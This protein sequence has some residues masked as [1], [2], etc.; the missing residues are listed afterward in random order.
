MDSGN[1]FFN[2]LAQACM[3]CI[4]GQAPFSDGFCPWFN[5]VGPCLTSNGCGGG[6]IDGR[7]DE[8]VD[9]FQNVAASGCAECDLEAAYLC[10]DT[11]LLVPVNIVN[12]NT[13]FTQAQQCFDSEGCSIATRD[14]AL[15]F[16]PEFN[17]CSG[18]NTGLDLLQCGLRSIKLPFTDPL[19]RPERL[20]DGFCDPEYNVPECEFDAGDCCLFPGG[21][22]IENGGNG[23]FAQASACMACLDQVPFDP[24]RPETICAFVG[25]SVNCILSNNCPPLHPLFGDL[26]NEVQIFGDLCSD[27]NCD[28]GQAVVCLDALKGNSTNGTSTSNTTSSGLD[29]SAISEVTE[30]LDAAGC[31]KDLVLDSIGVGNESKSIVEDCFGCVPSLGVEIEVIGERKCGIITIQAKL[32]ISDSCVSAINGIF[33]SPDFSQFF[34][35]SWNIDIV[36]IGRRLQGPGAPFIPFPF[37]SNQNRVILPG[38]ALPPDNLNIDVTVEA[39]VFP[40]IKG[41]AILEFDPVV[42]VSEPIIPKTS[43][44]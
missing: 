8:V 15:S 30:C 11:V 25:G 13:L 31:S 32:N 35:Y 6:A 5:A 24:D 21:V 27:L 16:F 36:P 7:F 37:F 2:P 43:G 38:A 18:G 39:T 29:C 19:L 40:D 23:N 4:T 28:Q 17:I 12:C 42:L 44:T 14:A 9:V 10:L 26:L 33:D 41:S 20:G 34:R 1:G 22:C 3:N